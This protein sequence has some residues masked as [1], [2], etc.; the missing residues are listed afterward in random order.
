M[1][2][3]TSARVAGPTVAATGR[4]FFL[5]L[6]LAAMVAIILE[7]GIWKQEE[8]FHGPFAA[9]TPG[10]LSLVLP[11]KTETPFKCCLRLESDTAA[12]PHRSDLKLW[13]NGHE[14]GPAHAPH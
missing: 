6:L 14:M 5:P 8:T 7:F 11:I 12:H 13:I 1:M 3:V 4:I 9:E 10:S 2:E